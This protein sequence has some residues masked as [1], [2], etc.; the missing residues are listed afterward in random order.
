[1]KYKIKLKLLKWFYSFI[2]FIVVQKL[3]RSRN[4]VLF[5]T[6]TYDDEG[7]VGKTY[8]H[9]KGRQF[10]I[11][12]QALEKSTGVEFFKQYKRTLSYW[13][14]GTLVMNNKVRLEYAEFLTGL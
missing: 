5:G 14:I 8:K 9:I 6:T 11:G 3:K 13:T 10:Q 12:L 1:M 2:G 4:L 7:L